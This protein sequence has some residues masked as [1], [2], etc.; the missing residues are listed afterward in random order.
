M[1]YD[2]HVDACAHLSKFAWQRYRHLSTMQTI[3]KGE[4]L[5]VILTRI[6]SGH[7]FNK[8]LDD[9]GY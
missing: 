8:F 7:N 2:N 4:R 9:L 5:D 6:W 3:Q 1:D